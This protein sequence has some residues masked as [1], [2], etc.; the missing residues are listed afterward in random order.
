MGMKDTDEE[1]AEREK[2][3][4]ELKRQAEEL[5]G[6][7]MVEGKMEDTPPE[8]VEGFW[9][10]VVNYEKAPWTT[11]FKQ[12]EEAGIELPA[13]ETL[14]DQQ[15]AKKLWEVIHA[16]ALLRVFL[17]ETDHL[18][19]RELYTELWSDMLRE[20]VKAMPP[21]PD[22]AYHLSPLGGCSE[23]DIQLQMKYYADDEWRQRFQEE[24][25]DFVMPDHEDPPYDRD[26]LLPQ[27]DYYGPRR[28][29]SSVN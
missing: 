8:V 18:S 16:L 1:D 22:G 21:D 29:P 23:E 9:Q 2:R 13:P 25:P 27:P 7:K 5:T 15:L 24:F 3:I 20:E 17:E 11:N 10:Y 12:L 6:G 19:D 26:R 4:A 14:D 28:E